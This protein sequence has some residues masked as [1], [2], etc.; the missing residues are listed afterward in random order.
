VTP[1]RIIQKPSVPAIFD[2]RIERPKKKRKRK[3][4]K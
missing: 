2:K 1:A 3:V 4:V